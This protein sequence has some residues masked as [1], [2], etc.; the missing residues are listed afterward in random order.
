MSVKAKTSVM[1]VQGVTFAYAKNLILDNVSFDLKAG[2]YVGIVGPNGGG[3]TTLLKIMLGL[4]KPEQGEVILL[5]D[6]V[7]YSESRARIGYVPQRAA[8]EDRLFPATVE[9]VVL[10]GRTAMRGFLSMRSKADKAAVKRAM[11]TADVAHLAYRRIGTLSGGERQRVMIARALA[12][13][14]TLLMLDEPTAAV[15]APSQESFYAFLRKL[16]DQGLTIVIVSHDLDIVTHEVDTVLC[17][18]KHLVCHGPTEEV[19]ETG[20]MDKTYGKKAKILHQH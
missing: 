11:K 1:S 4:L 6:P 20:A 5:G 13:D 9:E 8:A 15:D 17:L 18:N 16:H 14:P 10:S 3:K 7:K 2:D 19:M 12:G